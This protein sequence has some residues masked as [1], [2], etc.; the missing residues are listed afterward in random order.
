MLLKK[1]K[2]CVTCAELG[3]FSGIMFYY[4]ISS[5]LSSMCARVEHV[6]QV[7][8]SNVTVEGMETRV[9]HDVL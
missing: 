4:D 5:F 9:G 8:L 7:C 6:V 3:V 2:S 1:A